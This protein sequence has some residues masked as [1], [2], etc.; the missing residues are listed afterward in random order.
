MDTAV[1]ATGGSLHHINEGLAML[2]AVVL[3]FRKSYVLSYVP[4]G[5][6]SAGPH[7][8][9]VSITRPGSFAVRARKGYDD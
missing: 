4:H 5:V 7:E 1:Q 3:D 8:I 2:D 6:A 9:A